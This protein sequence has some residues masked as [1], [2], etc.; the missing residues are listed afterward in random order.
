MKVRIRSDT[1]SHAVPN[2]VYL[3]CTLN[4]FELAW[5]GHSQLRHWWCKVDADVIALSS[6]TGKSHGYWEILR[7]DKI[8]VEIQAHAIF[9]LDLLHHLKFSVFWGKGYSGPTQIQSSSIWASF[10]FWGVLWTKSNPKSPTSLTIF[11]SRG[12][13]G[14]H[15][16]AQLAFASHYVC[17]ETNQLVIQQSIIHVSFPTCEYNN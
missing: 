4:W 7:F 8:P 15:I 17:W 5:T 16:A 2:N 9:I 13:S 6:G 1:A 3:S 14:C 11:I 10:H 12:Y